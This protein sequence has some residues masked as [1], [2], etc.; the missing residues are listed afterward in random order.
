MTRQFKEQ[1]GQRADSLSDRNVTLVARGV[2]ECATWCKKNSECTAANFDHR[3]GQCI[4]FTAPI[5]RLTEDINIT[6][7]VAEG[8]KGWCRKTDY[9]LV[10]IQVMFICLL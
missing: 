6:A 10:N 9:I 4:I 2:I 1:H 7:L 3:T 5:L 8:E